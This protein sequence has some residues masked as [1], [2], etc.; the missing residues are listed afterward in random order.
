MFDYMGSATPSRVSDVRRTAVNARA[1]AWERWGSPALFPSAGSTPQARAW[2]VQRR[3]ILQGADL[4]VGVVASLLA[5]LLRFG[6]ESTPIL[7][8]VFVVP[9][10]WLSALAASGTYAV[11]QNGVGSQEYRAI[12][13]AAFT[14]FAGVAIASYL[15]HAQLSRGVVVP[16][17]IL[18]FVGTMAVHGLHR[19]QLARARTHGRYIRNVLVMGR[20]DACAAIV[21]EMQASAVAGYRVVGACVTDDDTDSRELR[22]SGV[23]VLGTAEEAIG[24]VDRLGIDVV[25][26]SSDPDLSGPTLRRIGWALAERR[27]DLVV[28]PGIFE[29]AGPRLS[30]HPVAGLSLLHVERPVDGWCRLFGKR[31]MDTVLAGVLTLIAVPIGLVVAVLIKLDSPGPVFF[32]QERVG[33]HGQRFKMLKFRSMCQH[34]EA[35]KS[36]VE[37]GNTTNAVL[38]KV[39][40]DPRITRVGKVIRRLSIDELPQLLNVLVGDMSLVGPRP[41]LPNEV[42]RYEAD[43]MQRL[44]VRPGMTGMWQISGRSDLDWEQSLRL[45]LWYVDNWSPVLDLQI[46]ARTG[47]AVFGGSGAY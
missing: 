15:L 9:L 33:V 42:D 14:T 35:R 17:S 37:G 36:S 30:L 5:Y 32:R 26:V 7:V 47:R 43:A 46:L 45:D 2:V 21:M 16:L 1:R 29:V 3:R 38:F 28:A 41:S 10:V 12:G 27:V 8:F 6:F 31:L 19:R 40:Q 13:R 18:L 11:A 23:P 34:A 20:A 24:V 39:K 44:R 25:A 22:L 4:L